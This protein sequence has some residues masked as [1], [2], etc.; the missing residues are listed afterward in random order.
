MFPICRR[1]TSGLALA[2]AAACGCGGPSDSATAGAAT[3]VYDQQSGK[4][5]QLVSDR[6]GDGKVETRAFMDGVTLKH[7][8]IDRNGDDRPDRWEF[9]L[10]PAAPRA[11]GAGPAPAAVLSH[12][13]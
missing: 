11:G 3:P 6:D 1:R 2:L 7:I 8:E 13:E 9:Y 4:L 12:V 10:P 5:S